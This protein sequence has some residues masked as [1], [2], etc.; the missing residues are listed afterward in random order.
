[1]QKI[2]IKTNSAIGK[3]IE[4]LFKTRS[5][6]ANPTIE[7]YSIKYDLGLASSNAT[8]TIIQKDPNVGINPS[9]L[10][11]WGFYAAS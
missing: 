6:S 9:D 3:R 5:F 4:S 10:F 8:A 7:L 1:M 11:F 2:T